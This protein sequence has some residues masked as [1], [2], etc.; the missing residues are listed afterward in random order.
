MTIP[1]TRAPGTRPVVLL[2]GS[3]VRDGAETQLVMLAKRLQ[4][5]DW[6]VRVV[7]MLPIDGFGAELDD[8]D[9]HFLGMRRGAAN[10]GAVGRFLS[11]MREKPPSALV[12]FTYPANLFG[13]VVGRAARIPV[14]VS[15]IRGERV[16]GRTKELMMRATAR[17]D[18][19]TTT[20]SSRVAH[21]LVERRLVRRGRIQVIHNGVDL[22]RFDAQS[23][24][25]ERMRRELGV[26]DGTFVWLAVGR[27]EPV[28]DYPNLL[29]AM[30]RLGRAPEHRLFVAGG[31]SQ[32]EALEAQAAA[33]GVAGR[34]TFLGPRQDV[35]RLLTAADAVVLS[36]AH[37]G[38]PNAL[39]EAFAA[40][41]PAV[42]TD[43]GGVREVL[44]DGESGLV[45]PP[46]DPDTLALAMERLMEIPPSALRELGATGRQHVE[47]RFSVGAMAGTWRDL[48]TREIDRRERRR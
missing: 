42:A 16:G 4:A 6:P 25:R 14:V 30:A 19:V 9:V 21:A 48:L 33:L 38:M 29:Q 43:V 13:R 12:S 44:A 11:L 8:L 41:R 28:K 31:G 24:G 22:R 7:S 15:S 3:L 5:W 40:G 35:P 27:L 10:V 37:E 39:M 46:H 18:T 23:D 45:V 2:V 34:V 26:D 20:N 47:A 32:R 17:L 36:S 1:A